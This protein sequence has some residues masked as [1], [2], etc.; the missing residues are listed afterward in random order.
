MSKVESP[1][2]NGVKPVFRD[3][4]NV[5]RE[6]IPPQL[7]ASFKH[8]ALELLVNGTNLVG[9]ECLHVFTH[10]LE[11]TLHVLVV[12]LLLRCLRGEKVIACG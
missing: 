4:C 3:E 12:H 8:T 2:A 7:P 1:L 9:V 5:G 10:V 6:R 11:Q